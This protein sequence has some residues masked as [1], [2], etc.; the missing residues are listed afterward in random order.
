MTGWME[1]CVVVAANVLGAAMSL[2][3]AVRLVRTRV[4]D[5]V[6]A[7]WALLSLV[8]NAWWVAYGIALGRWAIVPVAAVSVIGYLVVALALLRLGA[9]QVDRATLTVAGV[10]LVAPALTV[11]QAGWIT[12][13]VFLGAV[14]AV[15][16]TPAVLVVCR[17]R[18][19]AGVSAGTWVFAWT[20]AALWGVYGV[21]QGDTGVLV[22]AAAGLVMSTVVLGRL[23]WLAAG[24]RR[25]PLRITL[26]P[27]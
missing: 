13:G 14:Y 19:L 10:F 8:S 11:A 17:R 26:L 23:A 6:S 16:L 25:R 7:G 12:T 27:H 20:E 5:G 18:D 4:V 1:L 3:Q 15:Q 2:P 21:H 22:L 24:R 9:H